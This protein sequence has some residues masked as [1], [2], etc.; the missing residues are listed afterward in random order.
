[1]ESQKLRHGFL[2]I[3]LIGSMFVLS[4]CGNTS[5]AESSSSPPFDPAVV[6]CAEK[7]ILKAAK[8]VVEDD[9]DN[10]STSGGYCALGVRKSLQ[11]SKVGGIAGG[12]GNAIDYM[13]NLPSFG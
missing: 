13:K 8:K 1:M 6:S 9:F 2:S 10:S 7:I 12:I 11:R 3:A 4:G 5:T